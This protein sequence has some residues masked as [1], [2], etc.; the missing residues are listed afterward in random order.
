[1]QPIDH[2]VAAALTGDTAAV[3]ARIRADP[4]LLRA[5]TMFGVGVAHAAHFGG[6]PDIL[7]L[8]TDL[9]LD[10]DSFLAAELG[11]LEALRAAV[12]A[13]AAFATALNDAGATALHGAAYFGQR[14]AVELLLTSGADANALTRDNFLQ[15]SVLG[16]AIATTPGV[17]QPSDDE[18]VVL[19]L[20]RMLLEAGAEVDRPRRDGTTALHAA[21]WRGLARVAQELVDAG[22][23]T[24]RRA[25]DGP[26]AG[27]TPAD[28]AYAQG[29]LLL[30]V[31][32]DTGEP[33]ANP[34]A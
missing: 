17:H 27:E 6:H 24:S 12:T 18:G 28:T 1:V 3:Q 5:R 4:S 25:T 21:S 13:D 9:G 11:Q 22:A 33:A 32:L 20:V 8:L 15:I 14:T 10:T 30:A 34:Y 16:S 26:H 19:E 2:L 7:V 31:A 29:H 23:D